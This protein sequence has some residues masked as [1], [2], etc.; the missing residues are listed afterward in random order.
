VRRSASLNRLSP[1][2]APL[3]LA[4]FTAISAHENHRPTRISSQK[5]PS[6]DPT[7][8]RSHRENNRLWTG[9]KLK[10]RQ[11]LVDFLPDGRYASLVRV[12]LQKTSE[13]IM[14]EGKTRACYGLIETLKKYPPDVYQ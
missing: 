8:S 10:L 12:K 1:K 4:I 9:T 14:A 3:H 11:D 2:Q 7:R 13:W 6:I 5:T